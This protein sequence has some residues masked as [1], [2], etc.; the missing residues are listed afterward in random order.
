MPSE[1]PL[2]WKCGDEGCDCAPDPVPTRNP[3]CSCGCGQRC[4][5][6]DQFE[7]RRARINLDAQAARADKLATELEA[8]KNDRARLIVKLVAA[9]HEEDRL[10]AELDRKGE[11]L[12]NRDELLRD[13]RAELAAARGELET[14]RSNA[15]GYFDEASRFKR[16]LAAAQTQLQAATADLIELRQRYATD[17][18]R[19]QAELATARTQLQLKQM[20]LDAEIAW[21]EQMGTQLQAAREQIALLQK[22]IASI[23][24]ADF[25]AGT[26]EEQ[27]DDRV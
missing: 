9:H 1:P 11:L 14:E 16:E 12:E 27:T 18:D 17:T 21:R 20:E 24:A 13:L 10:R 26:T 7:L 8:V 2:Y 22:N 23:V 19:L 3:F 6:V 4:E 25:S 5:S 15:R